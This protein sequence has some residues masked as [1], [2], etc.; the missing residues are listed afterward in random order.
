VQF[1]VLG[2]LSVCRAGEPVAIRTGLPSAALALLLAAAGRPVPV[3]TFID[4]LWPDGPP[5]SARRNLHQYVHHLRTVIGADRIVTTP[6][7]YCLVAEDVDAQRFRMLAADGTAAA[8]PDVAAPLLRAALD[9]W[10]GPVAYPEFPDSPPLVEEATR[11]D[12]LRLSTQESWARVELARDRHD[13]VL[14]ELA[15]MARAHPYREGLHALLMRALHRAGHP[16]AALRVFEELREMLREQ[17]GVDPDP[18]LQRLH[19]AILR[20]EPATA[21]RTSEIPHALPADPIGFVGRYAQ[22]DA[23]DQLRERPGPIVVSGMPGVGKTALVVRWAHRVA[24]DF[25]DGQLYLDLGGLES[26][27]ILGPAEALAALL[28]Q[29]GVPPDQV[30]REVKAAATRFR[31]LVAGRRVLVVLDNAARADQVRPLL[32][33]ARTLVTSRESLTGLVARDGARLVP[34]DTLTAEEAAGLLRTALGTRRT[35]A[36]PAA[37]AALAEACGFLPLA[38]RIAAAALLE[39]P[40]ESIRGYLGRLR[41][42]GPLAALRCDDDREA[43]VAA[44]FALSYA[45][46]GDDIRLTFRRVG[47]APGVDVTPAAAAVLIDAPVADADAALRRLARAS[48]LVAHRP[49]RYVMHDLLRRYARHL[50]AEQ[51]AAPARH[52]SVIALIDSYTATTSAIARTLYP[53]SP[54]VPGGLA[55][56]AV[57]GDGLAWL[58]AERAN[59]V[60]ATVHAARIGHYPP[61]WVLAD[62]LRPYHQQRGLVGDL[63]AA[64]HAALA[65]ARVAD[66][67]AGRAAALLGLATAHHRTGKQDVALRWADRAADHATA[68]GWLAG[69]AAA[70]NIAA[71]ALLY[72][73]RT[74]HALLRL[75]RALATHTRLGWSAATGK[76]LA[77][78]AI[79]CFDRD[80]PHAGIAYADQALRLTRE[81]PAAVVEAVALT[82]RGLLSFELGDHDAAVTALTRAVEVNRE[83][84]G[85]AGEATALGWLARVHLRTGELTAAARYADTALRIAISLGDPRV[86]AE[87]LIAAAIV[88]ADTDTRHDQLCRALAL[89]SDGRFAHPAIEALLELAADADRTAHPDGDRLAR[90]ALDW[91][92]AAGLRRLARKATALLAEQPMYRQ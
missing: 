88:H 11:L 43:S 40:L 75:R 52:A 58:D 49:G 62:A 16:A 91:A 1:G 51:D 77:N 54:S 85:R 50:A 92:T 79:V 59:L 26:R 84:G 78:L 72:Q 48:L 46:L 15:C 38:L 37:A 87:A 41:A 12:Q 89:S 29:L 44:A 56:G 73:G 5:T 81:H 65:A 67:P 82:A 32:T 33:D 28:G 68:A 70:H 9:L 8:D 35:S 27:R 66:D 18:E 4:G 20:G 83:A 13:L 80:D 14:D 22:L 60:A 19:R 23:L 25:P 53:E 69:A 76:V 39:Q 31:T 36:E 10:R 55:A 71:A 45:G 57:T 63:F 64:S 42:T 7:G 90:Q 17:L 21:A 3:V 34:L 24:A 30:P 2:P 86:E 74:H 61:A 47:D 6:G